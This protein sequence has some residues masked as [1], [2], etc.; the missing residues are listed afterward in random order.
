M[1]NHNKKETF[2]RKQTKQKGTEPKVKNKR[3]HTKERCG[4]IGNRI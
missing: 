4:I 3:A 2:V 1:L